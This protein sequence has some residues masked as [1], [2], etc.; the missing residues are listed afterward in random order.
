MAKQKN[1]EE[2]VLDLNINKPEQSLRDKILIN[3]KIKVKP[4]IRSGSIL[5]KGHDG[6]FMYSG[7]V[8]SV[9]LPF[10]SKKGRLVNVL[11]KE[12]EEFLEKELSLE[13]GDLSIYKKKENFWEQSNFH[14]NLDKLGMELDLSDPMDFI[15]YKVL[16]AFPSIAPS[17]D[18]R[19][20]DGDYKFALVDDNYQVEEDF[21]DTNIELELYDNLNKIK[22]SRA[23]MK[24]VLRVYG[25]V[26]AHDASTDFLV[27]QIRKLITANKD[28]KEKLLYIFN[29]PNFEM[30]V[31]IEKALECGAMRKEGSRYMLPGGDI[32]GAGMEDTIA[33]LKK[34]KKETDPIYLT[35]YSKVDE[36]K[37]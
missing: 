26:P 1:D 36:I 13:K 10:D 28:T 35:I 7:T 27:T 18:K 22:N 24:D 12:E 21:K 23:K 14:I 4:I 34:M 17:W 33:T 19:F 16:L 32:I 31:F 20:D 25:K 8:C 2:I 29:D 9:C 11:T 30:K 37:D 5:P 3:K 15:R 6:E